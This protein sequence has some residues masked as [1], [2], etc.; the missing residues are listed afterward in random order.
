MRLQLHK[1]DDIIESVADTSGAARRPNF[2]TP[3]ARTCA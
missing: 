3:R 1:E 2:S